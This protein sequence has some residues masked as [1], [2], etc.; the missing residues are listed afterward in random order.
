MSFRKFNTPK[1][2]ITR[3]NENMAALVGSAQA[4]QTLLDV[5]VSQTV[6]RTVG[7]ISIT[8]NLAANGVVAMCIYY[9]KVGEAT[10]T[11]S[12][13][14]GAPIIDIGVRDI[15]WSALLTIGDMQTIVFNIDIKGMRKMRLGDRIRFSQTGA[16][17]ATADLRGNMNIFSKEV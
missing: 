13:A 17:S 15:L 16:L 14:N 7:N 8:G 1:R 11:L 4:D 10:P 2:A 9:L 3:V 12:I 5:S 6:V